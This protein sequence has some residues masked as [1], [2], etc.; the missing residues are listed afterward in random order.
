MVQDWMSLRY[1]CSDISSTTGNSCLGLLSSGGHCVACY[2]SSHLA[3]RLDS[4]YL[5]FWPT[6]ALTT[7]RAAD[8]SSPVAKGL[9][10]ISTRVSAGMWNSYSENRENRTTQLRLSCWR[11]SASCNFLGQ[12]CRQSLVSPQSVMFNS[13]LGHQTYILEVSTMNSDRAE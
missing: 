9:I 8:V 4:H 2:T 3:H 5:T 7:A 1:T 13:D 12:A 10:M 6:V 11:A